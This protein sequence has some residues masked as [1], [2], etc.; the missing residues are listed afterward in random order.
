MPLTPLTSEPVHN[1][2]NNTSS[3]W[4]SSPVPEASKPITVPAEEYGPTP[5]ELDATPETAIYAGE[6]QVIG[7]TVD[8]DVTLPDACLDII[9]TFNMPY[10]LAR[11]FDM[12]CHE[13]DLDSAKTVATIKQL[14]EHRIAQDMQKGEVDARTT[15]TTGM[16]TCF[17]VIKNF[18]LDYFIGS[19][20][21]AIF[22]YCIDGTHYD[23]ESA[24]QGLDYLSNK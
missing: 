12:I 15:S 17:N 11:A 22:K 4:S 14:L 3:S 8:V 7:E 18:K 2:W 5:A 16:Q 1:G 6:A 21:Q 20:V 13:A 23:L 10:D 9:E 19:V 24:I